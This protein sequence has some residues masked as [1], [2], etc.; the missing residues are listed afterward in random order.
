MSC[1]AMIPSSSMSAQEVKLATIKKNVV[2]RKDCVF[3]LDQRQRIINSTGCIPR[4]LPTTNEYDF[5]LSVYG[6]QEI[7]PR[8][9]L[10]AEHAINTNLCSGL[11]EKT[12]TRGQG[13]PE[14]APRMLKRKRDDGNDAEMSSW[15]ARCLMQQ[16]FNNKAL[17]KMGKPQPDALLRILSPPPACPSDQQ[18]LADA[19]LASR[20]FHPSPAIPQLQPAK[21]RKTITAPNH[22]IFCLNMSG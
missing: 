17:L 8:A 2:A 10:L 18:P 6:P 16:I 11:V 13:G 12:E 3:S 21:V 19:V 5:T 4:L 9:M 1:N 22:V 15:Q 14:T 7:L 20:D